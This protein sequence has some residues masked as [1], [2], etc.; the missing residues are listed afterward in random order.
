MR[1]PRAGRDRGRQGGLT[2]PPVESFG[3]ATAWAAQVS[4]DGHS[5]VLI[6]DLLGNILTH[7]AVTSLANGEDGSR[8]AGDPGQGAL[9]PGASAAVAQVTVNPSKRSVKPAEKRTA[10]AHGGSAPRP[11]RGPRSVSIRRGITSNI[12]TWSRTEPKNLQHA[13]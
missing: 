2:A 3:Y 8:P 9:T 6:K 7:A 4:E 11:F 1:R 10:S 12:A 13:R 5:E